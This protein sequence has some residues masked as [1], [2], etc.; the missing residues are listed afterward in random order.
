MENIK[1]PHKSDFANAVFYIDEIKNEN[2]LARLAEH[3]STIRR[4]LRAQEIKAKK[5]TIS[6]GDKVKFEDN[7]GKEL[8][9]RITK[10]NRTRAIVG[11]YVAKKDDRGILN[12][13][14]T[15]TWTV[16]ITFLDLA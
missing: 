14:R 6:V 8:T 7:K 13:V 5:A 9:G 10:V 15:V 3:I 12:G 1:S 4:S 11:V 16:P 2:D